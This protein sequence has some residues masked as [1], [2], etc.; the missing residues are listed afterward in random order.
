LPASST[1]GGVGLWSTAVVPG[2]AIDG[3]TAGAIDDLTG[4]YRAAVIATTAARRK[5]NA[6]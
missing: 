2:M 6:R 1:I 3:G 4:A 5:G